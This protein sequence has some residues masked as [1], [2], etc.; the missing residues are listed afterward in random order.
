MEAEALF[1]PDRHVF[2]CSALGLA[3]DTL[4]TLAQAGSCPLE[5][6]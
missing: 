5:F 4:L 2:V 6:T 1:H 3:P